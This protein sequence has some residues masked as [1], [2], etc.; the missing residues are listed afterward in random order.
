MAADAGTSG[1]DVAKS[2][3]RKMSR[4]MN[5]DAPAR[6]GSNS[7]AGGPAN[8]GGSS[9]GDRLGLGRPVPLGARPAGGRAAPSAGRDRDGKALARRAPG[10]RP[11]SRAA[12]RSATAPRGERASDRQRSVQF[13]RN[14]SS[15]AGPRGASARRRGRRQPAG[16]DGALDAEAE[17]DEAALDPDA[18]EVA[19]EKK[20]LNDVDSFVGGIP[21]RRER[22]RWDEPKLVH[23]R[24]VAALAPAPVYR[25]RPAVGSVGWSSISGAGGASGLDAITSAV[26]G[27]F[28]SL[29]TAR[30]LP[31]ADASLAELPAFGEAGSAAVRRR[32]WGVGGAAAWSRASTYGTV[33]PLEE[34]AEDAVAEPLRPALDAAA[35]LWSA[36]VPPPPPRAASETEEAWRRRQEADERLKTPAQR[37]QERLQR[38]RRA[39]L[40]VGSSAPMSPL[41][42]EAEAVHRLAL[43]IFDELAAE[44][45]GSAR[46]AEDFS[47]VVGRGWEAAGLGPRTE[48][49]VS[50]APSRVVK[51]RPGSG[52]TKLRGLAS[53]A[54]A[55]Q[56]DAANADDVIREESD[57][58]DDYGRDDAEAGP[59][60]ARRRRQQR[61]RRHLAPALRDA[62]SVELRASPLC[63]PGELGVRIEARPAVLEV[64]VGTIVLNDHPLFSEED[65]VVA[66]LRV[67]VED[68]LSRMTAGLLAAFDA[69][70][71]ALLPEVESTHRHYPGDDDDEE[72][73]GAPEGGNARAAGAPRGDD[74]EADADADE[75]E[76]ADSDAAGVGVGGSGRGRGRRQR[77]TVSEAGAPPLAPPP[78]PPAGW[79]WSRDDDM[80]LLARCAD[81]VSHVEE[82]REEWLFQ[83]DTMTRL[84]RRWT[85]VKRVRS[86]QR[87]TNTPVVLKLVPVLPWR[88]RD[89]GAGGPEPGSVGSTPRV[90]RLHRRLSRA[91]MNT[92]G[93]GAGPALADG[94]GDGDDEDAP[95]C[96]GPAKAPSIGSLRVVAALLS[97]LRLRMGRDPRAAA[98][99]RRGRAVVAR[100]AAVARGLAPP[101]ECGGVDGDGGEYIPDLSS[102][103]TILTPLTLVPAYEQR[104]RAA[105]ERTRL[106]ARVLVNGQALLQTAPVPLGWPSFSAH[107]GAS[108]T[109]RVF[110]RPKSVSVELWEAGFLYDTLV[111][112]VLAPVPGVLGPAAVPVTS[113]PAVDAPFRFASVTAMDHET[114]FLGVLRN[115]QE[116][117]GGAGAGDGSAAAAAAAAATAAVGTRGGTS[118][119][120]G[121]R[122]DGGSDGGPQLRDRRTAGS[123]G[124]TVAWR[125]GAL[126]A[127]SLTLVEG[128]D[129]TH[130][131]EGLVLEMS[132]MGVHVG[133]VAAGASSGVVHSATAGAASAA[134]PQFATLR[135]TTGR[136]AL[137]AALAV[138]PGLAQ[139]TIDPNDPRNALVVGAAGG[140]ALATGTGAAARQRA[141]EAR[142]IAAASERF[143]AA[144]LSDKL[145]FAAL[146]PS[147]LTQLAHAFR[148]SKGGAL[149]GV[150]TQAIVT[151]LKRQLQ[152]KTAKRHRL[153][154]L[155][156]RAAHL[157]PRRPLPMTDAEVAA[158]PELARLAAY[159]E[160]AAE[161]AEAAR[162]RRL[163][164]QG[165]QAAIAFA[166]GEGLAAGTAA[167]VQA[168]VLN[169]VKAFL[170]R[171]EASRG[172]KT[173][174][175]LARGPRLAE[176]V[177]DAPLPTVIGLID[178][179]WIGQLFEP[180]RPLR[181]AAQASTL[182][183]SIAAASATAPVGGDMGVTHEICVQVVRARNIPVRAAYMVDGR[184]IVAGSLAHSQTGGAAGS[185]ARRGDP[186]DAAMAAGE[187]GMK[188]PDVDSSFT[189][190]FRG[191]MSRGSC[192]MGST[193]EWNEVLRVPL[194]AGGEGLSPAQLASVR[195]SVEILLH[196]NVKVLRPARGGATLRRHETRVDRRYLG[197]V[198]IPF[199]AL[200]DQGRIE[201]EF[202]LHSPPL[203]MGYQSL[204]QRDTLRQAGVAAT[205]AATMGGMRGED[206]GE[207]L[208]RRRGAG[209]GADLAA[210]AAM[211]AEEEEAETVTR[212]AGTMLTAAEAAGNAS[213]VYLAVT[214]DPPLPPLDDDDGAVQAALDR[215]GGGRRRVAGGRI[216]GGRDTQARR[217]NAA[218]ASAAARTTTEAAN[219]AEALR[220]RLLHEANA[221]TERLRAKFPTRPYTAVVL[222][223]DGDPRLAS[224]FVTPQPPPPSPGAEVRY[225]RIG[226]SASSRGGAGGRSGG[227]GA[228][229]GAGE[230]AL[231]ECPVPF[232]QY[233]ASRS[234]RLASPEACIRYV[235]L[236]P[237]VSDW[238]AFGR[239]ADVWTTTAECLEMGAGDWEEHAVMLCNLLRYL[240]GRAAG[241][242]RAAKAREAL[243]AA[244]EA[245]AVRQSAVE[246][247]YEDVGEEGGDDA[248]VE[249]EEAALGRGRGG[250]DGGIAAAERLVGWR[251]Y[252]VQGR[253]VPE[254]DTSYVLRRREDGS[255]TV[256]VNAA[257]GRSYDVRDQDIPMV[258]VGLVIGEDNMWANVQ[259]ASRP[260]E[261]SWILED[262]S[263]WQRF[264]KAGDAPLSELL[265]PAQGPVL[266]R[267]PTRLLAARLQAEIEDTLRTRVRLWRRP[268]ATRTAFRPELTERLRSLLGGL[269]QRSAAVGATLGVAEA[270]DSAGSGGGID[271]AVAHIHRLAR[272]VT[273]HEVVG[274]PVHM[275]FKDMQSVLQAVR[276]TAVHE[277]EDPR[278]SFAVACLTTPYPGQVLSV[279]VY[280][281]ALIPQR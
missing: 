88:R 50:D 207:G 121:R 245:A 21:D 139:R 16:S 267:Q 256:L 259:A 101:D 73:G 209:G 175:R 136:G 12:S 151:G 134:A 168:S 131:V 243:L 167:S 246:G 124:V 83:S 144:A 150:S 216:I 273:G 214:V 118:I 42:R 203:V 79:S 154:R 138:D 52:G 62:S 74:D 277:V 135:D 87:T 226:G 95:V 114:S 152:G 274:C 11:P 279:W 170:Q 72:D 258:E 187:G 153:L 222:D 143:R 219:A 66:G 37:E 262:S 48:T 141:A 200:Y 213:F 155:R 128:R 158:D 34:A 43:A 68:V 81:A 227:A 22:F 111:A 46:G 204:R 193:S 278:A 107:F 129:G 58:S 190:R 181:P 173:K 210:L 67:D 188:D 55:W 140:G 184:A 263:L 90:R 97:D 53:Q 212:F 61:R 91:R 265:L 211:R 19:G 30:W 235:S 33:A 39:G 237:F 17:A 172:G 5:Q 280:V 195:D 182:A 99:I 98:V 84:Y 23:R 176:V 109:A 105:V 2:L 201:G 75:D 36:W 77:H 63:P 102:D 178:L 106:R 93:S 261:M 251:S 254:G 215:L 94:G 177:R 206:A 164:E 196:D 49:P 242:D 252:V 104:R 14:Q 28:A 241:G 31:D 60:A 70:L 268:F 142:A 133:S 26:L 228:G 189:L 171:V 41:Q 82:R 161:E 126:P 148:R 239:N 45:A 64:G 281:L 269:E 260:S 244:E 44:R 127:P 220:R 76:D 248:E 120:A 57:E 40:L 192:R 1:E 125:A 202:P 71:A 24:P 9:A 51:I 4:T 194:D 3:L 166:D 130:R 199:S 240:E 146:P 250:G 156:G 208:T 225:R 92:G 32:L 198:T 25:G 96:L 108:A 113:L 169:R 15:P 86:A 271:L 157:L 149:A 217:K 80:Q 266:Y 230:P 232:R 117:A 249:G 78:P 218:A 264:R 29:L 233:N 236:L 89:G 65:R 116:R 18:D 10:D 100:L 54:G 35:G 174:R 163:Q 247:D 253:G 137:R 255:R 103:A 275:P 224:E 180:R 234:P 7:E 59:D 186:V 223:L 165:G 179:S 191:S 115:Q 185:L 238:D 160:R 27:G 229:A 119:G 162:K 272:A 38:F 123:V 145:A 110:R 270:W 122:R 147:V 159:D 257:T 183:G 85:A 13:A 8:G 69:R 112:G 6:A 20:P 231:E 205:G 221:W 197:R 276:H 132:G 47:A 56:G